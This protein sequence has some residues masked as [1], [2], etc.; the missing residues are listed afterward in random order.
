MRI[1]L[2]QIDP[3][4][5]DLAGNAEKIQAFA[6]RAHAQGATLAIFPELALVGYPPR[7]LV[8]RPSFIADT[9]QTLR[10]LLAKLPAALTCL[11]GF[12]ED[13]PATD[14]PGLYNALAVVSEGRVQ[15]VARKR[16]LPSYD[17]FDEQRYFA[18]GDRS[19]VIEVDGVRCGIT[20]CEDIWADRGALAVRRY[21]E[22]PVADLIRQDVA[23]LINVAASPFTLEKRL[24][25][26]QLLSEVAREHRVPVFFV[27]Q[28]GGN[29][30]LI[31]DGQSS[32]FDERGELTA[33]ALAFQEDLL[34]VALGKPCSIATAPESDP[35]AALEA[36]ALGVR[37]YVHKTGFSKVVLGLSGGIDSALTAAIAVRGLGKEHVLGVA[38]PSRY[39]SDH[40]RRDARELAENLA[41]QFR[42]LPIEPMFAGY[43][44]GLTPLLDELGAASAQDVTY[45]NL[46]AR[47]R[48]NV[49]MAIANR[50]GSLL[51]TTGN[52]SE[53]AVG[54]CT[55]YGD[56]AGALA[57]I[58]DLPK[59][60]VYE[61]SREVNRQAGKV[62][63]PESTLTKPPSAELRP[64]QTDQ[65]SLPPYDVL[66]AILELYVEDHASIDDIIAHGFEAETVRRIVRL[67]KLNEYKRRQ[68]APGL[69]IT[70]KAFGSGRRYPIAQ[71]YPR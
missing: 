33:R 57:V 15:G 61:V 58:A 47:I 36:L 29:D 59:L 67:V 63:I 35:A 26:A 69:I 71:R 23:V 1:A 28:V 17:V 51:L 4:V 46:Q 5:G 39:S 18:R 25:R 66:D 41:I 68:M 38:M 20:I 11:I 8:D 27:N 37:D 22:N 54:Y 64:N 56:M 10:A 45:E 44:T 31:F 70:S 50:F 6:E 21:H 60:A 40:S 48:G 13:A 9:Q 62:V 24:G 30:E 65:D 32:V 7:D 34:V 49:L 53:V 42:E 52:K 55:L 16:L 3:V 43:H 19:L 2:C 14:R 12:V